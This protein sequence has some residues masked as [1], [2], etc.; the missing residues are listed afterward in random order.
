MVLA[1]EERRLVT[2]DG[3]GFDYAKTAVNALRD[4]LRASAAIEVVAN[5]VIAAPPPTS[6]RQK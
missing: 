2:N 1:R 5:P 3:A 4:R 6:P